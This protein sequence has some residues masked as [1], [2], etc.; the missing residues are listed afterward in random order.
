MH[1]VGSFSEGGKKEKEKKKRKEEEK[2]KYTHVSQ[3]H[4]VLS[5]ETENKALDRKSQ[6]LNY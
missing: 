5:K 4:L 1:S 2:N 3:D 6:S